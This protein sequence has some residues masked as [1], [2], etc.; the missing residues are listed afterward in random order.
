L[1]N[2]KDDL[3]KFDAKVDEVIFLGCSSHSHAYNKRTM[4]IQETLHIDFDETNQRMQEEP[5]L[6]TSDE[7][8]SGFQRLK[9]TVEENSKQKFAELQTSETA[10]D[11]TPHIAT[12]KT[13]L[14]QEWRVPRNLSLDNVIGQIHMGVSTRNS[15]NLLCEHMTFVS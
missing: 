3:G 7:Q 13:K 6:A 12:G 9:F 11:S 2:C 4:L 15:I 10:V 1:N 14:P 5:K 8:I